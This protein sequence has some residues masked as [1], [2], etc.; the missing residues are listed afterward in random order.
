MKFAKYQADNVVPEW[1][2]KYLDVLR[3]LIGR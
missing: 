3:P 2:D 1:K